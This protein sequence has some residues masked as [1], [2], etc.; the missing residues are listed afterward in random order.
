MNSKIATVFDCSVYTLNKIHDRAGNIT[1]LEDRQMP[2][3]LERIYYL[4]DVPGGSERGAHAHKEM[5]HLMIAASGSFDVILDDGVNKK[6]V[7]LNRPYYGLHIPPGIWVELTNFSSGAISLNIVS[8]KYD[9]SDYI[10]EYT[11]FLNFKKDQIPDGF[12]ILSGA[13]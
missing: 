11:E 3:P 5:H 6:I 2:F 13:D 10:R 4:Y 1:V 7:G 8:T 9:E 12:Q